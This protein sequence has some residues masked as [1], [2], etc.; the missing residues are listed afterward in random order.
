MDGQYI[1]KKLV[2]KEDPHH[3]H[4]TLGVLSVLSFIYR[5]FVVFPQKG[6]L[7][8]DGGAFDWATMAVHFLLSFSSMIFHVLPKR[9]LTKPTII[10]NEYRL[11]AISF[12]LR[13]VSVFVMGYFRPFKGTDLEFLI[14]GVVVLAHHVLADWITYKYGDHNQTTVRVNNKSSAMAT[15]VLRFYS[16]YQFSALASHLVPNDRVMDMGYNTLIAIQSSSFLMTLFRKGLIAHYSHA[17]WY[18]FCL[19]ISFNQICVNFWDILPLFAA[20][21]I[22]A[23][24]IRCN[25]RISKYWIWAGFI[26]VSLPTV[27]RL[28]SDYFANSMAPLLSQHAALLE[29]GEVP[30]PK[31]A[32]TAFGLMALSSLIFQRMAPQVT[33][34][35][36]SKE[37]SKDEAAATTVESAEQKAPSVDTTVAEQKA[38]CGKTE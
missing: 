24:A 33:S 15:V 35:T 8:F 11:H 20:K 18:T 3:I 2:T 5:Y 17:F 25:T 32:N 1:K 21:V 19:I 31:L 7:G 36:S 9:I 10:W 29:M 37:L 12:T 30:S 27:E 22:V 28:V 4:K 16:F 38:V 34:A 6:N 26:L 13:C 14:N 23:F